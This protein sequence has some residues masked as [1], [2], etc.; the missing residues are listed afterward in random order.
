MDKIETS[1]TVYLKAFRSNYGDKA[2]IRYVTDSAPQEGEESVVI[3]EMEVTFYDTTTD[4]ELDKGTVKLLEEK[5]EIMRAAA[6]AA[7]TEVDNQIASLLALE[8]LSEES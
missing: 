3:D 6:N 2:Y 7:I 5:R 4:A 1:K 8:N